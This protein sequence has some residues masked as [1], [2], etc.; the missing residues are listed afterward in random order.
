MGYKRFSRPVQVLND[1]GWIVESVRPEPLRGG[2]VALIDENLNAVNLR[3]Y[4]EGQFEV[5]VADAAES[6]G[7]ALRDHVRSVIAQ[8][9]RPWRAFIQTA[10]AEVKRRS[11][12]LA[13]RL[14]KE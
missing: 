1:G 8:N 4:N 9:P 10:E 7:G 6:D 13:S 11:E 14:K 12:M 2:A 5:R 3:M